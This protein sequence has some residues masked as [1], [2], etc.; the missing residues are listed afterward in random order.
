MLGL[1][2]VGV[3]LEQREGRLA[4]M[5]PASC[6]LQQA[7]CYWTAEPGRGESHRGQGHKEKLAG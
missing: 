6:F 2:Q 5:T 3:G 1:G 7:L 4:D